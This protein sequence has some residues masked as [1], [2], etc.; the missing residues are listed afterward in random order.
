MKKYFL[1]RQAKLMEK[2]SNLTERANASTDVNEVRS[3]G[4]E[5]TEINEELAMIARQLVAIEDEEKRASV[6]PA[7]AERVNAGVV[8]A[9]FKTAEP[10][11]RE[12]EN[13]YASMEYRMAFKDY[14]QKGI[15]IPT[16]LLAKRDIDTTNTN[17]LGNI[18]PETIMNEF[19]NLATTGVYGNLFRKVRKLNI[20][21]NVKFPLSNLSA[22]VKWINES[23]VSPRQAGGEMKGFIEFSWNILEIRVAQTLLSSIVAL[24]LFEREIVKVMFEEYVKEMEYVIMSGTGVGQPL[25]I[26]NDPRVAATGNVV[27]F[28]A[29]EIGNWTAWKKKLFSKMPLGHRNGE[30]VFPIGTVD[31]YLETMADSNNNPIFKAATGLEVNDRTQSGRF[32][33]KEIT[34]VEPDIIADF[35]TAQSGDVIGLFWQP[36]QYAINTQQDFGM[37]RYFDE[38]RNEWVNKALGVVDGKTLDP[39]GFWIIKKA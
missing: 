34:L 32:F 21:G 37:K 17:D 13:V 24:D 30:F 33:G 36:N 7:T 12:K 1:E 19:I 2:K 35:D 23:T 22:R 14:V 5:L 28:T 10:A 15:A 11:K 9:S 3:I 25:G 6:V 38:E 8:N 18:I 27:T 26:L 31:A 39:R 20:K 4:N 29:A 16:E